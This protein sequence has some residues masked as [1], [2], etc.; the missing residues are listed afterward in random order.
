MAQLTPQSPLYNFPLPEIEAWLKK[1]GCDQNPQELNCWYVKKG[2]W[3]AEITL[4]I[5]DICVSY[6]NAGA[7]GSDIKRAFP[8]SLSR[9]DIEDAV[10]S[11]P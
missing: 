2:N 10:F 3:E 6:L 9:Q 8:Y 1:M 5:E 11:G 7:D 4:D